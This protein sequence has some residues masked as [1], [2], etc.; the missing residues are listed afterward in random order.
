MTTMRFF[1]FISHEKPMKNNYTGHGGM[2][3][4]EILLVG[5]LQYKRAP[6]R[7][8]LITKQLP[9]NESDTTLRP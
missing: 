1:T 7:W 2:A 5:K 9:D 4:M 6:I 8:L 3:L